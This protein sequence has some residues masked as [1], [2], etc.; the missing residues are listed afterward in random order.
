MFCKYCGKEVEDGT[1]FCP[2]CGANLLEEE[3]PA[4]AAPEVQP[5]AEP[6]IQGEPKEKVTVAKLIFAIIGFVSGLT[7]L[8]I[9]WI[10]FTGMFCAIFGVV[11][12]ACGK[13]SNRCKGL[14]IAGL[15]LSIIALVVGA[16][17]TI[18]ALVAIVAAAKAGGEGVFEAIIAYLE[19]LE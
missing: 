2:S 10:P 11:F 18:I 9:C 14:A 5:A 4:Q 7:A 15:V 13:R 3:K 6:V 16:I 17:I 12:S 19:G 8:A 1:K